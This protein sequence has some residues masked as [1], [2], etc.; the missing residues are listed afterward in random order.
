MHIAKI[1]GRFKAYAL[2]VLSHFK[3]ADNTNIENKNAKKY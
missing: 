3:L 2:R 1:L